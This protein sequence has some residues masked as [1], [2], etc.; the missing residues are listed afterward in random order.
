MSVVLLC[1]CLRL[2]QHSYSFTIGHH[3]MDTFSALLAF[4]AG[5]SP[6]TS[7]F[8]AQRPVTQSFDV[9]FDQRLNNWLCKQLTRRW[10]QTTSRPSWRH[11]N[12]YTR[13]VH[14]MTQ[15]HMIGTVW[16]MN[17]SEIID[18]YKVSQ[19]STNDFIAIQTMEMC[20]CG[21]HFHHI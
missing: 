14:A 8:P 11:C 15:R 19:I 21:K 6:V 16:S 10:F 3:H 4:C 1:V 13:F 5:N 17:M 12:G 20:H 18:Q 9:S 7:E 2:V